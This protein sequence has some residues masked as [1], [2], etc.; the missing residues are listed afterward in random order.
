[1]LKYQ[2]YYIKSL[3]WLFAI[4]GLLKVI[5]A[6]GRAK[7]LYEV[8]PIFSFF[9]NR[10]LLLLVAVVEFVTVASIAL[11]ASYRSK[12]LIAGWLGSVFVLYRFS[13]WIYG[14]AKPCKCLGALS[15]WTGIRA[16]DVDHVAF[17]LLLYIMLSWC[18]LLY[19]SLANRIPRA[20]LGTREGN[21]IS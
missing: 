3:L 21:A 12:Y 11:T 17:V 5:S 19:N 7:L 2:R 9:T 8:D 6:L 10:Q 1:M 4:T 16:K 13:L 20:G 14:Y 15:D 18:F